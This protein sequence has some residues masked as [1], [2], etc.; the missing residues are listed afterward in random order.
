MARRWSDL[1]GRALG[2]LVA[3]AVMA[4]LWGPA[5]RAL[6]RFD[7]ATRGWLDPLLDRA[8]GRHGG[9]RG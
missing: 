1:A 5:T 8:Q 4:G 3:G 2:A 7:R 9:R 6:E